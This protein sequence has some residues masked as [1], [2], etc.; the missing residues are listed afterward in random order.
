MLTSLICLPDAKAQSDSDAP[1]GFAT[2]ASRTE[3][4]KTFDLTGGGCYT[5]PVTGVD[6][7]KV[8]V[9]TAKN[10]TKDDDIKNAIK[11]YSVIVFDGS[12]G[13]IVVNAVI[14]P[15]SV[16]DKTL[17]GINN[18]RLVTKWVLNDEDRK[19]LDAANVKKASTTSGGGTLSNGVKVDEDAEFLV[20][21]TF[22]QK[23]G[24]ENYRKSG[25]FE[26]DKCQNIIIRNIKFVGPG[27]VDCS[28][29]DLL[30]FTG[31]TNMWVD[32]C[33]FTDG[34]D[35]NFDITKESDFCTVSWCKFSYTERAYMHMNTNLVGGSDSDGV[36]K[37]NTTFAYNHWGAGCNQRMPMARS[38]I[39]HLLNNYYTCEGASLAINPR[40]NSEFLIEGNNIATTMKKYFEQK[41]ATAYVWVKDGEKAN[42]IPSNASTPS[43]KGT[44]TM[45]YD[46]NVVKA[47]DVP[48]MIREKVG[49]TLFGSTAIVDIEE[50]ADV[51]M[52]SVV[53]NIL[54][55]KVTD[56]TK[57]LLICNGK[58]HYIK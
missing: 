43:S 16:K 57:G 12:E 44:V 27:S 9:L 52:N 5:Y 4:G 30:A 1:F 38:G 45:P 34:I 17:L 8:K 39:I 33:E 56:G 37:L 6:A 53:Y 58:K 46:Y 7:S 11:N 13:D 24:N 48:A 40:K 50:S 49:T 18:A 36:G 26:L 28:G 25:V 41:D 15:G 19:L 2:M 20:R 14:N 31:C 35:G 23:Y 29:K 32:H 47:A 3:S 22:L 55:Q 21:K 10:V 42:V 51:I 54:G